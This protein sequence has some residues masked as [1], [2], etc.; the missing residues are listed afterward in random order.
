VCDVGIG[1]VKL[2]CVDVSVNETLFGSL[3]TFE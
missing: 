3:D 1:I 2:P